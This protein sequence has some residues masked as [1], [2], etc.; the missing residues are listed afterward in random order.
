MQVGWG[1][2]PKKIIE[3]LQTVRGPFNLSVPALYV[4]EV[5]IYDQDY[6]EKCKEENNNTRDWLIERLRGLGLRCDASFTNF[7]LPQ[8]ETQLQAE[9]CDTYLQSKGFIVRRVGSYNL[10]QFLRITVGDRK[11]CENLLKVI[12]EFLVGQ[13]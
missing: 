13:K 5:A 4:A 2:G 8:F 12:E 9:L 10:P 7:V 6:I 3:A 11:T 1:F